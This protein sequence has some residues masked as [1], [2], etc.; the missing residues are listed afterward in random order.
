MKRRFMKMI[1]LALA[2]LLILSMFAGC[3]K[4][5]P[6]GPQGPAGV[7]GKNGADGKSAYELAVENG[8]TGTLEQWLASL[9]GANGAAGQNG[10]DGKDG[11]NGAKGDKGDT[12]AQGEKGDTGAKG[13]KGDTGAQGEKGD[14]GAKGD[15]GDTGTQGEKGDTGAKG[16]KGDTGAQGEK[17]DTGA[18][19]EKGDTGAKGDKGDTG[20]T[21]AAGKDGVTPQLRINQT[22]NMW[23]VS[24]DKGVTWSSLDVAA[25]GAEGSKGDNGRGIKRIWLSEDIHLWVEY[26][27][28]SAP[29]DLGYVGVS[30]TEPK[31][32]PEPE[33]EPDVTEPTIIVSNATASAGATNVNV[34]IALKN[35]PGVALMDFKVSYDSDILTLTKMEFHSEFGGTGTSPSRLNSPVTV[36]WYNGSSNSIDDMV[37]VTL[38]F[39]VASNAVSGDS[40]IT[41]SYVEDGICDIYEENVA[42]DIINGKITIS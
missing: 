35:N 1:A 16:D 12:G 9:I 4:Q 33:P 10:A 18:Q 41:V 13:D 14:T 40:D 31:P 15:K 39:S 22:T 42:F 29:I 23:E 34:T 17:G 32:E 28:G 21:G 7:D 27:D 30:T 2:V 26:D 3:A 5:G 37:F 11:L 19:G 8:Y 24:Y 38:T 20:A 6:V 36:L 25:T